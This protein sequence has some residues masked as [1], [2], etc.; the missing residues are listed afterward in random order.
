MDRPKL[1]FTPPKGWCNDPNGLVFDGRY[2]HLFYQYYPYSIKEGPKHWGH[3]RSADLLSWEHLP[4]A[5]EPDAHGAIYSG[6]AVMDGCRMVLIFTYHAGDGTESQAIAYSSDNEYVAFNKYQG[7]PVIANPG[8]KDFRDPKVFHKDANGWHMILAAGDRVMLYISPDLISWE[9]AGEFGA[10]DYP[11]NGVWECPDLFSLPDADGKE[12]WVLSF[13]LGLGAAIGG[14]KTMYFVGDY[15]DGAFSPDS[16]LPLPVD[17]GPDFYAG[18][19]FWG[20][21]DNRRIMIAWMD[22]WAYAYRSPDSFDWRGQMSLP[23]ELSLIKSA[24]GYL[25][26][27][28]PIVAPEH[29]EISAAGDNRLLIVKDAHSIEIF[30][31]DSGLSITQTLI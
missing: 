22:N 9:K 6:S 30:A 29:I 27:S 12:K 18:V 20:I 10:P 13:S 28:V 31:P 21:P 3:A 11:V 17:N 24:H 7:N 14:G 19:T 5:L 23:R 16:P 4:V 26:S 1:H 15:K 8:I 25:L 2:Y